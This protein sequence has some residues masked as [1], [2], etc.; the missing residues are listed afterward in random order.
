MLL[1][2]SVFPTVRGGGRGSVAS[3]R[4]SGHDQWETGHIHGQHPVPLLSGLFW[5]CVASADFLFSLSP[6]WGAGLSRWIKLEFLLWGAS[7]GGSWG[8]HFLCWVAS[9]S[10]WPDAGGGP[11]WGRG[12]G[13][14]AEAT[15][16]R[17]VSPRR[18]Q[19]TAETE[20]GEGF[21]RL[22]PVTEGVKLTNIWF[23][24][25]YCSNL[26][27]LPADCFSVL[28]AAA[29]F[30]FRTKGLPFRKEEVE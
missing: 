15:L 30:H 8:S 28:G 4:Q 13:S 21:T 9:G 3:Q 25:V 18:S 19:C 1:Q 22:A 6:E 24:Y 14:P 10:E 2:E 16:D 20:P 5:A 7:V 11:L 12:K 23:W 26:S 29:V 27:I 17:A